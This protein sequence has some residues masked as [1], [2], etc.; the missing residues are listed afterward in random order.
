[1]ADPQRG[2]D[3]SALSRWERTSDGRL[4]DS[5]KNTFKS[6]RDAVRTVAF[7]QTGRIPR[8]DV[9][10][11]AILRRK[12]AETAMPFE[13]GPITVL[14]LGRAVPKELFHSQKKLFPVC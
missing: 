3:V 8:E 2:L 13:D 14:S 7:D 1:L 10:F 4:M 6:V 11:L 12:L 9:Y 5:E